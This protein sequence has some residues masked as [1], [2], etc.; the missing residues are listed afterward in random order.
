MPTAELIEQTY[1]PDQADLSELQSFL[2][3]AEPGRATTTHRLVIWDD[4][5]NRAELPPSM[6]HLLAKV[7][8]ALTN[9]R[10]VTIAPRSTMLTTQQAADLLGVSRPTVVRL[11]DAGQLP[12]DRPGTRRQVPLSEVLAYRERRRQHQYDALAATALDAADDDPDHMLA[13]LREVRRA[14]A[15][16]RRSPASALSAEGSA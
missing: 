9:G 6:H 1:L 5:G 2:A 14:V 7:V 8:D 15:S 16:R 12:A 13:Q 10:A 3:A 4:E 11:I